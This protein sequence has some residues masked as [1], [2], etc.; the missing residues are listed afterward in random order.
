[1]WSN[2]NNDSLDTNGKEKRR[3]K[4]GKK[5]IPKTKFAGPEQQAFSHYAGGD[6]RM[7]MTL[8]TGSTYRVA[9]PPL[10]LI[11]QS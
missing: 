1:V 3:K 8:R 4:K 9:R 5:S 7:F 11:A 10:S 6:E 2:I